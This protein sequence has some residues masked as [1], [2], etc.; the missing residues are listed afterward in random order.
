MSLTAEALASTIPAP[1][2]ESRCS[3]CRYV[4]Q[5]AVALERDMKSVANRSALQW[6]AVWL[7]LTTLTFQCVAISACDCSRTGSST[8]CSDGDGPQRAVT[9]GC[10]RSK[11][12]S[13][14]SVR[15]SSQPTCCFLNTGASCCGDTFCACG[16][17][18]EC[19][20]SRPTNPP[21]IPT[22]VDRDTHDAIEFDLTAAAASFASAISDRANGMVISSASF[23][24]CGALDRCILLSRFTC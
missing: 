2:V 6:I 1:C 19:G 22:P 24:T 7:A 10:G 17:T 4:E 9:S 8:C 12:T 21:Q 11:Q 18:C 16:V 20:N 23:H 3:P 14:R 15:T 13:C 5:T